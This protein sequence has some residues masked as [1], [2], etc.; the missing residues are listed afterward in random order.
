MS[1]R[2][3][4]CCLRG[5][6]DP[7]W[8][9]KAV[10]FFS[11]RRT[12]AIRASLFFARKSAL[13]APRCPFEVSRALR[14]G[15]G[16]APPAHPVHL[17]STV[18]ATVPR[19]PDRGIAPESPAWR[20]VEDR[21]VRRADCPAFVVGG[22][23]LTSVGPDSPRERPVRREARRW[24]SD[25]WKRRDM[26]A[27][28]ERAFPVEDPPLAS[29]PR[30]RAPHLPT[31]A[32]S[33]ARAGL[34]RRGG[35]PGFVLCEPRDREEGGSETAASPSTSVRSFWLRRPRRRVTPEW[36][37]ASR[38]SACRRGNPFR[39]TRLDHHPHNGVAWGPERGE[40]APRSGVGLPARTDS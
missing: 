12:R 6:G 32:S 25:A 37:A 26:S 34:T 27:P 14:N 20:S 31:G 33:G 2:C 5:L 11:E 22:A 21:W 9:L 19:P 13:R 4:A 1:A 10:W 7:L 15:S 40:P 28:G 24:P 8:A 30:W 38:S 39:A 35:R 17:R 16:A 36:A 3:A 23:R 29:P 18:S